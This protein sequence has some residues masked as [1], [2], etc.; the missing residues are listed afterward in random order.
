M[1]AAL[2]TTLLLVLLVSCSRASGGNWAVIVS[3]SRYWLNYRHSSNAFGVY[4]AIRRL[5]I[6]DSNIILMVSEQPACSP[7]NVY[8]AQ[9]YMSPGGGNTS[10]TSPLNLL[11]SDAEVDYRGRDVSVDSVLR[12]LTGHHLAG[13]P[14]SKRLRSGPGSRVL[15]YLTGHGGDEFLKFHDEEELLAADLASAVHQMA[16]GGRYGQL[17]LVADTCQASTLYSQID[18]PNMLAVASSKL[19][20]SSY[21]HGYIDPVVGQHLVDQISLHLHTFL[22][23]LPPHPAAPAALTHPAD[24]GGSGGGRR[25]HGRRTSG[26]GGPSMQELISY[27]TG[28]QLASEIEVQA[29]RSPRRLGAMPVT[30]FFGAA[31]DQMPTKH[32]TADPVSMRSAAALTQLAQQDGGQ[33]GIQQ[34]QQQQHGKAVAECS[35]PMQTEQHWQDVPLFELLQAAGATVNSAQQQRHATEAAAVAAAWAV[36]VALSRLLLF[37]RWK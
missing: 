15:L 18:A 28:Q 22:W 25:A 2:C 30:D 29:E 7:R 4:Q 32:A 14:A 35:S 20:K 26:G 6:P 17:L 8:A 24:G 16:A 12:V 36:A 1:H 10:S 11:S 21:A 19:G 9:L 5:G 31:A 34:Q 13:T 33:S 27:I 37:R 3:S 23:R